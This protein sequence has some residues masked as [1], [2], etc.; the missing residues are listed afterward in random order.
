MTAPVPMTNCPSEET[1]AAFIDDRL[2]A[3]SRRRVMEHMSV[4]ADCRS[5]L[6]TASDFQTAEHATNV[7]HGQFGASWAWAAA[8]AIIAAAF[9]LTPLHTLFSRDGMASLAKAAGSLD[10]R[11]TIPR[12]AGPFAYRHPKAVMRGGN[13]SEESEDPKRWTLAAEAGRIQERVDKDRSPKNLHALGVAH[14]LLGKPEPAAAVLAEALQKDTNTEDTAAAIRANPDL[15]LLLDYGTARFTNGMR[16][17]H[18]EDI[19]AALDA[20]QAVLRREP[21]NETASF[22]T[23]VALETLGLNREAAAACQRYLSIDSKSPW[24]DEIRERLAR[25]NGLSRNPQWN[26]AIV[27]TAAFRSPARLDAI[28][29]DHQQRVRSWIEEGVLPDWGMTH[30]AR[31]D[32]AAAR[33]LRMAAAVSDSLARI[34]GDNGLSIIVR[35]IGESPPDR[36]NAAAAGFVAYREGRAERQ[37]AAREVAM[38]HASESFLRS[39]LTTGLADLTSAVA[40]YNRGA[41]DLALQRLDRVNAVNS[42]SIVARA[43]WIRGMTLAASG[44]QMDARNAY[45]RAVEI[46]ERMTDDASAAFMH[47]LLAELEEDLGDATAWDHRRMALRLAAHAPREKQQVILN[48]AADACYRQQFPFAALVFQRAAVAMGEEMGDPD[49]LT[50]ALIQYG[51]ILQASGSAEVSQA[52]ERADVSARKI[53]DDAVRTRAISDVLAAKGLCLTA[54]RPG[55][56]VQLLKQATE[57]N[58]RTGRRWRLAQLHLALSRAYARM[59]DGANAERNLRAGIVQW[60]SVARTLDRAELREGFFGRTEELFEDLVELLAKRGDQEDA[61]R[62][63]EMRREMLQAPR[64]ARN[65][66]TL[67]RPHGDTIVVYEVLRDALLLWTIDD[68]GVHYERR[69]VT[70]AQLQKHTP[71]LLPASFARSIPRSIVFVPDENLFG[72]PFA[73]LDVDGTPLVEHARIR[74]APTLERAA[75]TESLVT[76]NP[77]LLVVAAQGDGTQNRWYLRAAL[78]DTKSSTF[79]TTVLKDGDASAANFT[80]LAPR[81][82]ILHFSGH[83]SYDT[84]TPGLSALYFEKGAI[85]ANDLAQMSFPRTRLIVLGACET[86]R[87]LRRNVAVPNVAAAFVIAGVPAVVGTL[88]D[89]DDRAASAFFRL[90]YAELSRGGLVTDAL[91][92]AQLTMKQQSTPGARDWAAFELLGTEVS[93]QRRENGHGNSS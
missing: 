49:L 19:V 38:A 91:R 78:D 15:D 6:M 63:V 36:Q 64:I 65:E 1:L 76:A 31:D 11:P 85:A 22:N 68:S 37:S 92:R 60:V 73:A 58:A 43:E 33:T 71:S 84:T 83:A 69:P 30:L 8:A 17:G 66:W 50:Y 72:V 77:S 81:Y 44:H 45:Q 62:Y 23:A 14:L 28:V 10:A 21:K 56:A 53:P 12:L 34:S 32:V 41:F 74:V 90:F 29:R 79:A 82:D 27:E 9:F 48:E 75:R 4:C 3:E 2:D 40:A 47:M 24:A 61:L 70:R 42:P 18:Q 67:P 86:A 80:T 55:Q 20:Y 88:W 39:G 13:E 89:V 52:L 7:T 93:L 87:N 51:L 5:V 59:G 25:I 26:P 54:N 16:T 46:F 35:R 57:L